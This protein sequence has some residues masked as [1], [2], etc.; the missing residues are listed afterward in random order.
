MEQVSVIGI[1]LAKNVFHLV[2]MNRQGR[3]V[4]RKRTSREKLIRTV[5][6]YPNAVVAL[7]ACGGSHYWAREFEK[8]GFEVK[9][10]SPQFVKPYVKSNKNDMQDAEAIAEA[11]TRPTMR[12]VPTKTVTQQ[13][14]Q[15]LHRAR[16]RIIR[17]RTA[18]INE[19]R[20]FFLEYGLVAP[21]GPKYFQKKLPKLL[22]EVESRAS[23]LGKELLK[24][25][26][27][28]LRQLDVQVKSY[29]EKIE[30][31]ADKHPVAQRLQTIPGIGPLTAVALVAAMGD[32][33]C[34]R[35]GRQFAA[36]LGLVPRQH[37][38][39]GKS[40]LLGISKRGDTT[41]RTLLIH[42]ARTVIRWLNLHSDPRSQ[43]LKQLLE[44]RGVN[45]ACVAQANKMAR[46]AWALMARGETYQ[47]TPQP[48]LG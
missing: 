27:E 36:W 2:G 43:W 17:G 1:D 9:M 33:K 46:M 30:E 26:V 16:A 5:S 12:F 25:L 31:L 11:A 35:N 15:F 4:I 22:Q 38:T 6:E 40:V 32:S 14:L 47:C 29:T 7:E 24:N 8:G 37:S 10:L 28:E 41:I 45:R 39:G 23:D 48:A 21:K 42:G 3:I 19:L 34:F 44:R 20:G 13:E 18:L